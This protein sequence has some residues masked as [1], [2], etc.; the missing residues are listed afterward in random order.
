MSNPRFELGLLSSKLSVCDQNSLVSLLVTV[1]G[2]LWLLGSF[3]EDFV[4]VTKVEQTLN[5]WFLPWSYC[6]CVRDILIAL[7][8]TLCEQP[9]T[10]TSRSTSEAIVTPISLGSSIQGSLVVLIEEEDSFTEGELKLPPSIHQAIIWNLYWRATTQNII[11][12]RHQRA[13]HQ[14]LHINLE[15]HWG[16][17][18]STHTKQ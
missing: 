18:T 13:Y 8:T 4:H 6:A 12:Y 11:I 10:N 5:P 2:R 1:W 14:G 17:V 9:G 3:K 16:A 15:S 7:R